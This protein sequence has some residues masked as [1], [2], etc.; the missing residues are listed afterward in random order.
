MLKQKPVSLLRRRAG[1]LAL[2]TFLGAVT[3]VAY[4][5]T[6]PA[7][8]PHRKPVAAA[9]Y[10]LQV[11]VSLDGKP[12][13]RLEKMC[14]TPGVYTNVDGVSA[15]VPP[16]QGRIAVL[17]APKGALEIRIDL[18]GGPLDEAVHPVVLTLPGQKATVEIAHGAPYVG[19]GGVFAGGGGFTGIKL[20]MTPAIGC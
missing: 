1:G 20:E 16:W 13:Q 19:D 17:P 6:T 15:G 5:A 8:A 7:A 4:A 18:S 14:L 11:S 9:R 12:A 2:I 3:G 10:S